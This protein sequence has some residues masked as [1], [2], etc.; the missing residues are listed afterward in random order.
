[1]IDFNAWAVEESE[2][3]ENI[4]DTVMEFMPGMIAAVQPRVSVHEER[5]AFLRRMAERD[6][7]G[8]W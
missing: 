1:M 4:T 5:A 8:M 6:K 2:K 7:V 3:A